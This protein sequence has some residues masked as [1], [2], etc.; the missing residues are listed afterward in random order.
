MDIENAAQEL[1]RRFQHSTWFTSVGIGKDA[2]RDCIFLY[3]RSL[4]RAR[5][6]FRDSLWYGYP[7]VLRKMRALRPAPGRQMIAGGSAR[8]GTVQGGSQRSMTDRDIAEVF[9]HLDLWTETQREQYSFSALLREV[10]D[11]R[12][13]NKPAAS[14]TVML[15]TLASNV[16]NQI[17]LDASRECA[18]DE[19]IR[20]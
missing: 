13:L 9:Q 15:E 16:S 2:G 8:L 5:A 20:A 18:M 3:V 17:K 11:L 10:E 19:D 6:S 1:H 14:D 12:A 7:V 4:D